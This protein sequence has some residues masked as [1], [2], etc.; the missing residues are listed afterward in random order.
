MT[1]KFGYFIIILNMILSVAYA[2]P[3]P[4]QDPRVQKVYEQLQGQMIWIKNGE[5]TPYAQTV[6]KTLSHAEEEGLWPEDY[7]PFVETLQ[8]ADLSSEEIQKQ[9]EGL[10]TLVALNY[11][12]DMKGGRL[13]NCMFKSISVK[14]PSIDEA[15][16]L[17]SYVSQGNP[18]GW[19]Y[20]VVPSGPEYKQLKQLLA[21]YRQKLEKGNKGPKASAQQR[22]QSIIVSLEKQRWFPNPLPA[23]Y[24]Q[25][26]V[27]GFYLKAV[28]GGTPVFYMP[29]IV[30]KTNKKTPV[31]HAPMR[32]IIFNPSWHVPPSIVKELLPKIGNNPGAFARKG[33]RVTNAGSGVRIVQSPG[34]GNAL[35]KIRFTIDSPF[36]IYLHGTP[37]QNLFRKVKRALSHGCIRVENPAKLAEF[38][39]SDPNWPL[40]RVKAQAQG[41]TTRR[42][43][44]DQPLPTY[45][46]YFTVFENENQKM[47]F[48]EDG[49]GQDKQ[50]WAALVKAKRNVQAH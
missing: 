20:G 26:N 27:A 21:E 24:L 12:S 48:V 49:Y 13:R 38:V 28:E 9:A 2:L 37:Q 31:F 4:A 45:I 46:T 14:P 34:N 39:L 3:N 6:L 5:W 15:E 19:I 11:I 23:R 29:I 43:K 7:T 42:V 8:N 32:E 35:G 47:T 25:V 17:T 10:L 36:A 50:V 18:G 22:I 40:D 33:Y 16:L 44:L 41:S 1:K 30:G